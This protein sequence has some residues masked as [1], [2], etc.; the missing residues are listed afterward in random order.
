[1]A[2]ILSRMATTAWTTRRLTQAIGAVAALAVTALIVHAQPAP[3]TPPSMGPAAPPT[4]QP[5]SQPA[6]QPTTEQAMFDRLLGN[7]EADA[8]APIQPVNHTMLD[9][10]TGMNGVPPGTPQLNTRREGSYV[11]QKIGRM[12]KAADG[13][14]WEFTLETDGAALQDPPMKLLPNLKLM[15]MEQQLEVLNRDLRFR[16]SGTVT[17]YRNRNYLL[18]ETVVVVRDPP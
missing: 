5:A 14:G 8:D 1:M 4:P 18:V 13:S 16:V 10:T 2:R 11:S 3:V 17:E 12:T 9:L 6:S 15:A 7:N